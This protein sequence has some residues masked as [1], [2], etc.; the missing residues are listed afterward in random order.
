M[1]RTLGNALILIGAAL[2]VIAVLLP[3]FLVPRL[4]VIPLDTVSDTSTEIREAALLDSALLGKNQPAPGREND[5]RCKATTDEEKQKLP[6]HCFINDKTPLQSK[7]HVE[8]EEP[9]DEK[10]ATMQVGTTMLRDDKEEPNN[11]VNATLDR[12][13]LNRSTAFPVEDPTS[14]VAINAPK[15]GQDTEP[16]TFPR[17]GIQYQFP[18][19]TEKKSYPYYDVQSM[20]N[21]EID[22][23]GEEEQAGETVYKYSMTIP[24]QNLYESLKE[25]FTRDGR[26]LTEA[27]KNTL[28][29]MRLSFPGH[30]W[31]LEGD[32]DVEMDRYYTNV[33]TVRVEP[34]SG[35]I[36]NGT[37]E[38]FMFYARD[39]KEAEEI[40]SKAGHE[41]ERAE[42]NR[43][44]MDYT[45]QW[46]G[47]SKEAQMQKAT[48]AMSAMFIGGTVAPWILGIVGLILVLVGF[49]VRSKG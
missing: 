33:R 4:R 34:T 13:T 21:F 7:R 17:P 10:V 3:T 14:S 31:G 30:K 37:E 23:V 28:A 39:A 8:I 42:R 19:G 22:F 27:D 40:A 44:A 38:M 20:R 41:K 9:A 18:F 25:H 49:R 26:K 24:P 6:V 43:T 29:S 48:D 2:I 1:K 15:S 32:E 45:A 36:V 35:V 16:P 11:L 47:K 46:D 12:I 5:P